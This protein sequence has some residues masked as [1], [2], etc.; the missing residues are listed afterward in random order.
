MGGMESPWAGR[1][2]LPSG[3]A[4]MEELG[5]PGEPA[6]AQSLIDSDM[7]LLKEDNF[8]LILNVALASEAQ[9]VEHRLTH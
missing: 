1:R 4:V 6:H 2:R 9:L 3:E 5:D 8:Y 7:F